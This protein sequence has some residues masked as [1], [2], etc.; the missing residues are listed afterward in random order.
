VVNSSFELIYQSETSPEETLAELS[1]LTASDWLL[2]GAIVVGSII[3]GLLVRFVILRLLEGR[4]GPLVANLIARTVFVVI[5][6]IGFVYAL[7]EVGVSIGPLFGLLGLLGLALALA[8]QDVLSNLIAGVML[9]IQRPFRVG[10][11]IK[12][13]GYNGTV[14]DVNLRTMTMR[15]FDGV[16]VFIPN[17]TVWADPIENFTSGGSRRTT[18]EIGVGYDS[19]LDAVKKILL[20]TMGLVEGINSDPVPRALV[21]EFGD[22]SINFAV[23][24]WHAPGIAD[25]WEVR[26]VLARRI[27]DE[28]DRAG[29][30]IPFPQVVLHMNPDGPVDIASG[31]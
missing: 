21:H 22:N 16:R 28:L 23:R 17:A 1:R 25:E 9:S 31:S 29:V 8:F 18:L 24:F 12:T 15:T 26:D 3:V 7:G 30:D 6:V 13:G 11:E 2:A 27:K 19:D 20:D 5:L 10:D 4:S 14:V